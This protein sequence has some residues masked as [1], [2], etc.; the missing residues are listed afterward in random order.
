VV[1]IEAIG[2]LPRV[3]LF[4]EFLGLIPALCV[5]GAMALTGAMAGQALSKDYNCSDFKTQ[6]QPLAKGISDAG[7]WSISRRLTLPA[8][9]PRR[10]GR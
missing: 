3:V 9:L 4:E 6:K 2:V 8:S 1:C 7:A 10:S 5:A